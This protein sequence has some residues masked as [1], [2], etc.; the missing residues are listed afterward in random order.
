MAFERY[1]QQ[2]VPRGA[3]HGTKAMDSATLIGTEHRLDECD[4]GLIGRL[5]IDGRVSLGEMAEALG[6]HRNTVK[7]RLNRLLKNGTITP[8]VHV[9]PTCL[10]Y[11]APATI[12]VRVAPSHINTVADQ[13][14]AFQSIQFV[15]VCAGAYDIVLS[16]GRFR[17][18]T[19]L[20]SF[21][22]DRLGRIRGILTVDTMRSVGLERFTLGAVSSRPIA[23]DQGRPGTGVAPDYQLDDQDRAIISELQRSIRRPASA[24]ASA[25]GM[26][27]KTVAIRLERLLAQGIA[28]PVMIADPTALG[29]RLRVILGVSVKPGQLQIVTDGLK[30]LSN[31]QYLVLCTGRHNML[32]WCWCRDLNDLGNLITGAVAAIPGVKEIA[33]SVVLRESKS[34]YQFVESRQ[35]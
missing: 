24:L 2:T 23:A 5:Q 31:L 34:P 1:N 15:H 3:D 4:L 25:L 9:D 16:G 29:Y 35:E 33:T 6:I 32:A 8:T 10:G 26:N 20:Y 21:V 7:A 30:S 12:G 27:R 13:V 14:A 28:R 19:D 17:S 11:S 22:T 18:E